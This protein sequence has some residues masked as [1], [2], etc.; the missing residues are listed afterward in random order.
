[1]KNTIS[2]ELLEKINPAVAAI[3]RFSNFSAIIKLMMVK[4]IH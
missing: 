3:N 2:P 4:S 1:M